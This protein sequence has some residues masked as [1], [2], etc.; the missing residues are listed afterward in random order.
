MDGSTVQAIYE[1][2]FDEEAHG[3]LAGLVA[4][5]VGSRSAIVHWMADDGA[6]EIFSHHYFTLDLLSEWSQR[7]EQDP[8]TVAAR[9]VKPDLCTRMTRLVPRTSYESSAFY[10]DW[11]VPAGDDTFWCMGLLFRCNDGLGVV[12]LHRG[13]GEEDFSPDHVARLEALSP[14]LKRVLDVRS[15]M[16]QLERRALLLGQTLDDWTAAVLHLG[17]GGRLMFANSAALALLDRGDGLAFR[18]GRVHAV[19]NG[20]AARLSTALARAVGAGVGDTFA[21]ARRS[22]EAYPATVLPLGEAGGSR[23]AA[24]LIVSDPDAAP[25]A[26][27]ER[28]SALYGLT[29]A[30]SGVAECLMEGLSPEQIAERRGVRIST[31][32]SLLQRVMHKAE[33]S[34]QSE[35]VAKLARL[36][37][38]TR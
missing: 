19:H 38:L 9:H 17:A 25:P 37:P 27:P 14:H 16:S 29:E 7:L 3:A 33:V 15:R 10:N 21:I 32:R 5:A 36:P 4:D 34:R 6:Q 11:V 35:L 31:V 28:W 26:S 13:A 8:W 30:E 22:G 12:T 20:S 23:E 1:S 24:L 2:A 18:G